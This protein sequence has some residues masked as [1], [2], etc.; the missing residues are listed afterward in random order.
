MASV[1]SYAAVIGTD[2]DQFS[3]YNPSVGLARP[4]QLYPKDFNNFAPRLSAAYDPF[5]KGKTIVRAG[6]GVFYDGY[7]QDFFT[8]Q[9]A[10]N[11]DNTGPAYNPVGPNP[12]FIT[13]NLNP[14]LPVVTNPL[15]PLVGDT[16][17]QP[18]VPVFDPASVTPT[19]ASSTDAFTVSRNL[20][21]PY[22]FNYNLNIQ[23]QLLPNTVLQVGYVG[24]AGR[25]LFY[26]RDINQ[27]SHDQIT[28]IDK[29]CGITEGGNG[30]I[31][32]GSAQC[33]GVPEIV[34]FTTPLSP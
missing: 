20:R 29:F 30:S 27:P 2:G 5:G 18:T 34:G 23:Q 24:S 28:R 26:F 19:T 10:Y 21:T 7:S 13:Y 15:N 25:K 16:I 6:V 3:I 8:G 4:S 22:V 31:A 32:R 33:L 14:A 17:I 12:V 9:L 1:R 11:T